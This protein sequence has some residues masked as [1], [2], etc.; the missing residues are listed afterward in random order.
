[1]NNHLGRNFKISR[2]VEIAIVFLGFIAL[3][4]WLAKFALGGPVSTDVIWYMNAGLNGIKDT[5]ILNRYFHVF[6]QKLFLTTASTPLIGLQNYWSFLIAGTSLLIYLSARNLTAHNKPLHGF[7]AVILLFTTGIVADTAGLPLVD[8]TAMFMVLLFAAVY[9]ASV[10]QR[11][12]TKILLMFLGALFFLAFKTKETTLPIGVLFLG[13]FIDDDKTLHVNAFLHRIGY[14]IAGI[15]TGVVFFTV[16]NWILLGDPLFGF[17]PNEFTKFMG[18]YIP[19]TLQN[20]K[21]SG[22]GNWYISHMFTYLW[23]PFTLYLMSGIKPTYITLGNRGVRLVWLLPL[24]SII[25]VTMSVGNLY[26]YMQRFIFPAIPIIC[27]LGPQFLNFEF[28]GSSDRR[29]HIMAYSIFVVGLLA[30]GAIRI[31]VKD[32]LQDK[33]WDVATYMTSVFIPLLFSAIL[34]FVFLWRRL[35]VNIS[36]LISVLII[37]ISA[38]PISH[39]IKQLVIAQ[40]NRIFSEKLFHPFSAFADEISNTPDMKFYI[41]RVWPAEQSYYAKDRVEISSLFNVYFDTDSSKTNFIIPEEVSDIPADLRK[42]AYSYVLL[43]DEDWRAVLEEPG[44]E[45]FLEKDYRIFSDET[46]GL[47]LLKREP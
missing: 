10:R 33:G 37:A 38:I 7:L 41:S 23:I 8:L 40:P 18:T 5:F 22:S 26:G 28:G 17:R 45:A 30:I 21:Y 24:L 39:N 4:L 46:G 36:V 11:H 20:E 19:L 32:S 9:I 47:V 2:L 44:L 14:V 35:S 3:F 29:Q 6:L 1:M 25:M 42:S 31:L 13:L 16:L 27:L 12:K 34:A 43:R 15:F